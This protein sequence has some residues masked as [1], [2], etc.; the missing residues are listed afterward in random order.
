MQKNFFQSI[1]A[2]YQDIFRS[3]VYNN[4]YLR[5][6]KYFIIS[7]LSLLNFLAYS[8][9][10]EVFIH[11][12]RGQWHENVKYLVE[13]AG[14]RCYLENKGI[15]YLAYKN[16]KSHNHSEEHE[17]HEIHEENDSIVAHSIKQH[18]IGAQTP[19]SISESKVNSYYRNYFIGND[20]SKWKS[21]I[22]SCEEVKMTECYEGISLLY[23]TDTKQLKYSW[24]LEPNKSISTIRWNYEGATNV[25]LDKKGNL[26]IVHSFGEIIESAP[27]SWLLI[28]GKKKEVKIR[29]KLDGT[30]VSFEAPQS[31][32]SEMLV[33]DPS[34]TFSTFTGATS[35]NWGM[36][37]T[38]DL[39][40]NL[41]AGGISFGPGYPVT[42][43]AFDLTWSGGSSPFPFDVAITKFNATGS[44]N[45][46]STFLGGTANETVHSMV[47]DQNNELFVFGAT[48]SINFPTTS[49]SY[50]QVFNGGFNQQ[51]NN[52]TFANGSDIYISHFSTN[53]SSLLG[54]TF[55]G[56][57]GNDGVSFNALVYNYGD[58]FRG[59]IVSDA[60]DVYIA[61]S[62]TSVD[63]PT[64]NAFQGT[65]QGGQD[66]V[67]FKMN[68][69]L[70]N[71]SWSSYFGGSLSDNANSIQLSS[72]GFV[73]FTGG[74][75]GGWT[76]NGFQTAGQGG[77]E[78]YIARIN[79]ASGAL[80]NTTFITT[81][82]YDQSY[83][84]QLD[85]DD[86][87]YV[88]GQSLGN[89][90]ITAGC[91]GQA[92]SGQFVQKY[93]ANLSQRI[94][95]TK[96]GASSGQV[97]ISPT[98]FLISNC[99]EIYLSG[100]G[101]TTNSQNA[102]AIFSSSS[103][104]P[105]TP[106]AYQLSTN[107][108]NFWIGVL[109]QDA[110]GIKYG[111]FMGGNGSPNHVDGGTSRFDKN[112]NIYHAVCASC[113]LTTTGFTTTP[114]VFS[115]QDLSDNCNLAAFKFELSSIDAVVAA[116]DPLVCL[117]DPVIFNNNSANGN[118]FFWNFGDGT[119]STLINPSHLYP[120]PGTYTVNLLVL[121]TTQCFAPDSIQFIVNI[122]EFA[123]GVINPTPQVCP[124]VPF[125]L[126][127]FGG[128]NYS[129]QPAQFLN[130]AT[131]FNPIA[132]ISQN[133]TFL[134]IITDSCG[135]DTVYVNAT[136][137]QTS[138]NV[139]NDTSICINHSVPLFVTGVSSANWSPTTYLS[140][141]T[142]LTP[143]SILPQ[144]SIVYTVS[145]TTLDGCQLTGNVAIN[146]FDTPPQPNIPDTLPY[147]NGTSKTVTVSGAETY[148]WFPNI[149]VSPTSGPTVTIS[150]LIE[151]FYYCDF[152]NA[153]GTVRDSLWV[154]LIDAVITAG[155]D[156]IVCPGSPVQMFANG[157]ISY[158]WTPQ[159]LAGTAN[160]SLVSAI[161]L[162]NTIYKVVGT[163]EFGCRD[164]A[165]VNVLLFPQPFIQTSPNVYAF[166]GDE[167]QLSATSTTPG[168]YFWS[169]AEFLS[170]VNCINPI[171]QPDKP[172]TY[173]VSYT[174]ANG[175]SASDQVTIFYDPLIFVP[176]TFTPDG[177]LVNNY[178]FSVFSNVK[179]IRME[180]FNRWG[181]LIYSGNESESWD[182]NYNNEK[183]Q[184]GVYVWKIY[185]K[186]LNSEE[187]EFLV[188]HVTL[189]R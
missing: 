24:L 163:D 153:C 148:N 160:Y 85:D 175:C 156:T 180:I 146:V 10:E 11:P 27:V 32:Y 147:C 87:V 40:G 2:T 170:C 93:N 43:G 45:L 36:S 157:G 95:A 110:I 55:I 94:W 38:P 125:Q 155:N 64:L 59:E 66:A 58:D 182:G 86:F 144:S 167:V 181:E 39:L 63:F 73:Y 88:Y 105:V 165:N 138:L 20:Q 143:T 104:F 123:G 116:P 151:Q 29:F 115:N 34:L 71:L 166:I 135:I 185:Y 89:I 172:F 154:D 18:W 113:G 121:D 150:S 114:G 25:Y 152:T 62:S 44:Q 82:L 118:A 5:N 162:A 76:A 19:E 53:G 7:L 30:N 80:V 67:V 178:F 77:S 6:M 173:T 188:G 107:G 13:G 128:S 176:N 120:G 130:N 28:D 141:P 142:S 189:I 177:N 90:P 102:Q 159:V 81:P 14:M 75:Q 139:S 48:S 46:F 96:I 169:P 112:G 109:K 171:A 70:N 131:I 161:P 52:L 106:D 61:T 9:K 21:E 54:S 137:F 79:N 1:K 184:D 122:G 74:T 65:S 17:S 174:D 15:T 69:A 33:I 91:Y 117:P 133:T 136:V 12:N 83:F 3:I 51:F 187:E 26:H 126:E 158:A 22:H 101:G 35:D 108:N 145:G 42:A 72:N 84:V 23:Q 57:S 49:G 47:V 37:A 78:G 127:A 31:S 97:E 119:T 179:E 4:L 16:S 60:T 68:K 56:G 98:A 134:C 168:T 140:N 186:K 149:G 111:T 99:K 129:W 183:C 41:Y 50:D 132:T 8:Q 124:N 92:N 164:S 103:G 100:W